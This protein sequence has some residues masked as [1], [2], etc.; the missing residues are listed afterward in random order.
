MQRKRV[1]KYPRQPHSGGQARVTIR[2]K[3]FYLGPF[4]SEEYRRELERA[5]RRVSRDRNAA[6]QKAAEAPRR[7]RCN[8]RQ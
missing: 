3:K 4:G 2:G 8:G 1:P 5:R 7:D 6:A